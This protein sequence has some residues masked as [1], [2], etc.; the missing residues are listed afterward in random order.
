MLKYISAYSDF[1]DT[2]L[3]KWV[4]AKVTPSLSLGEEIEG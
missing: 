2:M 4:Q 1:C 3:K